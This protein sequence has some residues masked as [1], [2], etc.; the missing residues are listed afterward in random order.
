M[1]KDFTVDD[2]MVADFKKFVASKN[3]KIEEDA[4]TKDVEFIRAMIRY[5]IDESVFDIATAKQHLITVDP[6]AKFAIS[7]FPD[8][9][10][11]LELEEDDRSQAISRV[12]PSRLGGLGQDPLNIGA[13][14]G[15]A[16][17]GGAC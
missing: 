1:K 11:L 2:A 15:L 10:K 5:A 16:T 13:L 17:T 12:E 8:A 4:W 7:K 14:F 3:V 6:Q 9:E